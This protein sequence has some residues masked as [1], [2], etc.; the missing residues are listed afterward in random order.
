[1]PQ[2]L[3]PVPLSELVPA[4]RDYSANGEE[5]VEMWL[6]HRGSI[7]AATHAELLR[8]MKSLAA[9]LRFGSTGSEWPVI[10]SL[11]DASL[12]DMGREIENLRVKLAIIA[13]QEPAR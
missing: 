8:R 5:A 3:S 13:A 7:D 12:S 10:F 4:A 6:Y 9:A 2:R 11:S 1:M